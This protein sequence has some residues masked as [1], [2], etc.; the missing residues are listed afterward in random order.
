MGR[1]IFTIEKMVVNAHRAV[2]FSAAAKEISQRMMQLNRF[3]IKLYHF[4]KS[5]NSLIRLII[6]QQ[7]DA[8][9]VSA[10]LTFSLALALIQ[11]SEPPPCDKQNRDNDE[12]PKLKFHDE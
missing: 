5:I 11:S 8:L 9:V 7:I 4:D 3:R 1:Q 2:K 6:Q 12:V 10:G